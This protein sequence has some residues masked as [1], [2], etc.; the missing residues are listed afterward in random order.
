MFRRDLMVCTGNIC[1]SP[2]AEVL[3]ARECPSLQ[4]ESAGIAA[5]VGHSADPDALALMQERG[6]DLSGHR[7]RQLSPSLLSEADLVLVM[8]EAQRRHIERTF[9][10]AR[11]KVH[12][13]GRFGDFDVPDPYR[14]GREEFVRALELIGNGISQF[15]ARFW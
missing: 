12:R 10:A 7:A 5:L 3:L 11:G 9:P 4:V 13:L 2:M 15:K 1:R 8:E 14:R 6:I